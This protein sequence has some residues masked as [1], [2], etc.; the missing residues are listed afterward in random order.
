MLMV[1]WSRPIRP[2]RCTG[3]ET[4][5]PNECV[6]TYVLSGALWLKKLQLPMQQNSTKYKGEI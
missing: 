5:R 3:I 6:W 4:E 2:D 1:E